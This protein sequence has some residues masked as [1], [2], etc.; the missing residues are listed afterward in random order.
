MLIATWFRRG[1]NDSLA[2]A[3]TSRHDE[4]LAGELARAEP[5]HRRAD[6]VEGHVVGLD[7]Q[8]ERQPARRDEI[9]RGVEAV[10]VVVV[11]AE[12]RQLEDDHPVVVDAWRLGAGAE[13]HEG[14]G[15]V[16][17]IERGLHRGGATRALERER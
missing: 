1:R 5:P 17:L 10:V 11:R 15:P 8:V 3:R 12:Q 6:R 7:Q 14:A 2:H 13:E 9:E 4:R 16:E